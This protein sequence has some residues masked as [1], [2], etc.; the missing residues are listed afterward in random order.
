MGGLFSS[1]HQR[2]L[3]AIM[4]VSTVASLGISGLCSVL[5]FSGLQMYRHQ[6]GSTRL[7][8]LVAGYA[9]SWLFIFMLTAI[10][11]LENVLLGKGFQARVLP[12][13]M[14]CLVV[15]CAAAG[16]FTES[17]SPCVCYVQCSVST[18]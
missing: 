8:T 14:L 11:N 13:V 4:G 12:E 7:L 18:I 5:V 2:N 3:S 6:L 9:A 1:Y 15:S 16:W 10:N 17:Q